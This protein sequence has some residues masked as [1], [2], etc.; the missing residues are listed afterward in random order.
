MKEL[1]IVLATPGPDTALMMADMYREEKF[2]DNDTTLEFLV[3]TSEET[4]NPYLNGQLNDKFIEGV[5]K[6]CTDKVVVVEHDCTKF[7]DDSKRGDESYGYAKDVSIKAFAEMLINQDKTMLDVI[8]YE[9]LS[10]CIANFEEDANNCKRLDLLTSI[11]EC[12]VIKNIED[13]EFC[14]LDRT[15]ISGTG[16]IL[17]DFPG[18]FGCCIDEN[19]FSDYAEDVLLGIS[20]AISAAETD[21]EEYRIIKEVYENNLTESDVFRDISFVVEHI[22]DYHVKQLG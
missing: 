7:L 10:I 14:M 9:A 16:E 18:L 8:D 1:K 11:F 4:F 20:D 13:V 15:R 19:Y 12:D 2:G 6:V 22:L 5:K 21:K 3:M 17:T